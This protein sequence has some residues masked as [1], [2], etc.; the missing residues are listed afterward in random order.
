MIREITT[1]VCFTLGFASNVGS[2]EAPTVRTIAGGVNGKTG[3]EAYGFSG[4]GSPAIDSALDE[5]YGLSVDS[6]GN[7]FIADQQNHRIRKIDTNGN[8]STIAGIGLGWPDF[9]G[10]NGPAV[11]ARL[12][13]PMDV[14]AH[15]SGEIYIADWG[16]NRIRK[17]DPSGIIRTVAGGGTNPPS[18]GGSALGA[19]L[20]PRCV[21]VDDDGT[22]YIGTY[23][24]RDDD[25]QFH[26][27]LRVDT[28]GSITVFAGTT[29]GTAGFDG[30]GGPATEAHLNKP[31]DIAIGPNGSVYIADY[32]NHRVRV[33]DTDGIITTFAGSGDPGPKYGKHYSGDGGPATEA[34]MNGVRAL[35]ISDAGTVYIGEWESYCVRAVSPDGIIR[36]VVGGVLDE[37]GGKNPSGFSGDGGPA[38][39]ALF[40]NIE[41]LALDSSRN[42]YISTDNQRIRVVE[43]IES[44]VSGGNEDGEDDADDS[45]D[46]FAGVI[47]QTIA[48]GVNGIGWEAYGFEGDGGPASES[49][50]DEPSGLSVDSDGNLF[51]ADQENH[52]IR[53]IDR[54]G[55]ISTVAGIGV[56][57]K[58]WSDS[59]NFSGD[60]G[61]AVNAALISPKDVFA[62]SSG[63][64]Y[65]AD[66]GNGR[67]RKIDTSG[68]ITT[69]AGGGTSQPSDAG[70]ALEVSIKPYCVSVDD[71]GTMYIGTFPYYDGDPE[72]HQILRVGSDGSISVFAGAGAA[73]FDG[74]GGPASEALLNRPH[75]VAIGI[76][77]SIFIADYLNHRVRMVDTGGVITT[78]AGS[79][80][81]GDWKSGNHYSGDNGPATEAELNGVTAVAVSDAGNVYIGEESNYLVRG[82]QEGTIV[83]VAG[84]LLDDE[85]KPSYGFSGDGGSSIKALFQEIYGLALDAS[86][87]LYISTG[88]HRIRVVEAIESFAND[89]DG[90]NSDDSPGD[91]VAL[92]SGKIGPIGLDLDTTFEDQGLRQTP[93]NPV[94]GDNIEVEVFITEGANGEGGFEIEF[95]WD[96]QELTFSG[97]SPQ[98]IF[99]GAITLETPGDGT[100]KLANVILGGFASKDSGSAGVATFKVAETF[101]G[102]ATI[103][104]SSVKLGSN[105]TIGPGASYVIIGGNQ[106]VSLTPQQAANFDGDGT[107]GFGDFLIFASGFGATEGDANYNLQLDLDKDGSVGFGDFLAFAAVFGQTIE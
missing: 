15:S 76:D 49:A 8:I 56:S 48:G 106:E 50:L 40:G 14:F 107:V 84:G 105:D 41:G 33:V 13:G 71:N 90:S 42:L 77:G 69:V 55:K 23:P 25:P 31:S 70:S 39:E 37:Y 44:S 82:V 87:N 12:F 94:A 102:E 47:V 66:H 62:H 73:G 85:G 103:T 16:N 30:D 98:D 46:S 35:A 59:N 34:I 51:I 81:A 26:Q 86:G 75:D 97:F 96:F 19:S 67:V 1:L 5:P 63:E 68:I 29:S 24:E 104:L 72:N 93:E 22:M 53:K 79:G 36:T 32:Q 88:N 38:T 91:T 52:R 83:T 89:S 4:D 92:P 27:I 11:D 43:G 80:E 61:L 17:I 18:G 10:D 54:D 9:E 7:L 3:W 57:D 21:A 100:M 58:V 64:I 99:A 74:D 101:T 78:F 28:E 65:I 95:A 2:N 20:K 60:N 45:T 6:E